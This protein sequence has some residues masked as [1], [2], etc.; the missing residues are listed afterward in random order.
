VQLSLLKTTWHELTCSTGT[1]CGGADCVPKTEMLDQEMRYEEAAMRCFVVS[2]G[3]VVYSQP[4]RW[5]LEDP[6]AVSG[7]FPYSF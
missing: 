4:V 3:D 5:N 2:P 1:T 6:A 7:T